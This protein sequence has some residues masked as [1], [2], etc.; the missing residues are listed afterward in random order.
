MSEKQEFEMP[1]AGMP[2]WIK[3]HVE[4]YLSDPERARLWDSTIAGGPAR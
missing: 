3:D 2:K 1:A 4:L